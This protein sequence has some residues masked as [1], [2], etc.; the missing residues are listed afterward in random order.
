[1]EV[2]TLNIRDYQSELPSFESIEMPSGG[3]KLRTTHY[4]RLGSTEGESQ[5]RES[6]AG[7][8]TTKALLLQLDQ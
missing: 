5:M 2:Y 1:M 8:S 7:V 6:D 4:L 3:C